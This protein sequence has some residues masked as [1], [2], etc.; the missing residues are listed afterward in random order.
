[1]E[2]LKPDEDAVVAPVFFEKGDS[3]RPLET[4]GCGWRGLTPSVHSPENLGFSTGM[5]MEVM[6]NNGCPSNREFS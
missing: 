6:A 3:A 5:V 1:M 4:C 2:V